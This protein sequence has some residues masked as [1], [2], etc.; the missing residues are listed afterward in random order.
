VIDLPADLATDATFRLPSARLAEAVA[1][2]NRVFAYQFDWPP[3]R[4]RFRACHRIDL[5]FLFGCFEA[6][7][8][9]P[10][11]AGADPAEMRALSAAMRAACP[12]F[13]RDGSQPRPRRCRGFPT[14][15]HRE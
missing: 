3:Q 13:V 11:L 7:H 12:A 9:A 10:M 15:V 4:S 8:D 5:P 2:R 1:E 14:N 6:W